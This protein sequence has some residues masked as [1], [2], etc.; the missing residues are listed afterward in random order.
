M[1]IQPSG[2]LN[3]LP[4]LLVGCSF[5]WH[6]YPWMIFSC[7]QLPF[8]SSWFEFCFIDL[9]FLPLIYKF[10]FAY[11]TFF[12]GSWLW[13]QAC[14]SHSTT[15]GYFSCS[16]VHFEK[17]LILA[18]VKGFQWHSTFLEANGNLFTF[19]STGLSNCRVLP[20]IGEIAFLIFEFCLTRCL[21]VQESYSAIGFCFVTLTIFSP[22]HCIFVQLTC[23]YP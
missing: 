2:T 4:L 14:C 1:W 8:K 21:L 19:S 17:S 11:R 6:C 20:W 12:S 3:P 5:R 16:F 7:F 10:S 15:F 22:D 9:S 23:I 13:Y 18:S